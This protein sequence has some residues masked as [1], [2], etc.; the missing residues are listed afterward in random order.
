LLLGIDTGGTYTDAV[1]V[2]HASGDVLAGAKA[3]TTRHN[4]AEG[5]EAAIAQAL[6]APAMDGRPVSPADIGL[7]AISTTLATNALAEG[8]SSAIALFLIGYDEAM[9]KKY[10]FD[11][12]LSTDNIVYLRGGHTERGEEIAPLDLDR[13]TQEVNSRHGKT[14]A[15]AVSGYFSVR[16]PAHELQV[17]DR[18]AELTGLPVTCGHELSSRLNAVRRA[19]TAALNA[20]LVL[21]LTELITS[22][23][24]TLEQR[25]IAAPLMVVKGD[26]SLI[27]ADLALQ[28][29]IETI[30][31]GPAA[32]VVGAQRLARRGDI[33]VVDVGGTT[34]DIASLR[35]GAPRLNEEGAEVGGWRT[36]VEAIDV[37]TTGLGGDSH[38]RLDR[39]GQLAIGP[40]RVIPLCLLADQHP[41]VADE[42]AGQTA[43]NT[44]SSQA[45][46]GQFLVAARRAAYDLPP[47]ERE[48]LAYLD[49]APRSLVSL[50]AFARGRGITRRSIDHIEQRGLARRAG[51]T[52]T[53]ALHVLGHFQRWDVRASE[54]G[55]GLL[56]RRLG[57]TAEALSYR[58]A[59]DMAQRIAE[60]L[61]TKVM[62]DEVSAANWRREPAAAALLHCAL[63]GGGGTDLEC[64]ITLRRPLAAV[65]APVAAYLPAVAGKLNT[66]LLIPRW[67]EVANAVGAVTGSV[68]QRA[69]ASIQPIDRGE[70]FRAYLPD[71]VHDFEQLE[72]AVAFASDAI[73]PLVAERAHAG[74]AGEVETQTT[75]RDDYAPVAGSANDRIYL[76]TE[77][78]FTATGRPS[79][80]RP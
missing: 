10:G 36:M 17:R 6:A 25:G 76:G 62:A 63:N 16:N 80:A 58:V 61:V 75:R 26:G 51:F 65:G 77:L 46:A 20:H 43:L 24:R 74:G 11:R 35:D 33:W 66:E 42:L 38:V 55:A 52:P 72:D 3:L 44:K 56:A 71:G 18:I 32:S 45:D 5:I 57:L 19:T 47:D 13:V 4:L 50:A 27:R 40:R 30:L 68:I 54:L 31:S 21:P 2:D 29:P 9:M 67:S 37:H 39:E 79:L 34:T 12:E 78:R 14:E 60:E 8:H 49:E 15:F 73:L 70:L 48:L 7:V 69:S 64:R 53:D 22:V 23:R 28:R 41:A 59:G 1:L